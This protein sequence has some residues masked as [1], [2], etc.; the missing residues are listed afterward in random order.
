M[1]KARPEREEDQGN[2]SPVSLH[3]DA[4]AAEP[5][6]AL[7]DEAAPRA[8]AKGKGAAGAIV[9]G[10]VAALFWVGVVGAYLGGYFGWSGLVALE[11]QILA[12]I[13]VAAFLPPI[14]LIATLFALT[15]AQKLAH[16][17]E[18]LALAAERLTR[19][20]DT[21][22]ANA[23][24]VGRVVRRELDAL[25][26]GLDG[27][28]GRLRALET[29]IEQRVAQLED[30]SARAG[31]KAEN[32][33]AKLGAER[34]RIEKM[35]ELLAETLNGAAERASETLAGR[36]AQ[37]TTLIESAGG[38]LQAAGT[39]L[40][41]QA[42][43]FRAAAEKAA[44]APLAAAVELDR[45]A[46]HIAEA[47]GNA[48]TRAE[49]VLA[50]Q[51]RQ[52]VAM[53]ELLGKLREEAE[54]L[55]AAL[56]AQS[57]AI[58]R[59]ADYL[60]SQS[61]HLEAMSEQGLRGLDVAMVGINEKMTQLSEGFT[62][63]AGRLRNNADAAADALS[64]IV[65]SMREAGQSSE[66]LIGESLAKA[67]KNAKDFIGEAMDQCNHLL[68]AASTV[69]EEAEKAR[70]ALARAAADTER[71]IVAL[72]GVA[73]QEAGRI[74]QTLRSETEQMLDISA[75]TLATLHARELSRRP[76]EP[77]EEALPEVSPPKDNL[78]GLARRITGGRRKVEQGKAEQ[79]K[80]EQEPRARI[81]RSS[82][83]YELSAVLAAAGQGEASAP[84]SELRPN[85]AAALSAVQAVLADRAIDLDAL[86]NGTGSEEV[87]GED[88]W[89]RYLGG[90]RGAF[91]HRLAGAIGPEIVDKIAGL[92]RD[93]DRFH[94]AADSYLTEFE[95]LLTRAR[96]SDRD[97]LLM[98]S[99]LTADTGKIYLAI[100]YALGR[101]N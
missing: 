74:R 44:A 53:T 51:E 55:D 99:L 62:D 3:R 70:A 86:M 95:A 46:N 52:R 100:A 58:A 47:A 68:S 63:E 93:D 43:S 42:N 11:P 61:E 49:F 88:V 45:Q 38:E 67:K 20:D 29:A 41:A 19:A 90:E 85:A 25:Q 75:R 50:R 87:G 65:A 66:A 69:A 26:T 32:I 60:A 9:F 8:R 94:Q 80:A 15:R 97:G 6:A 59:A 92:Y 27:A 101:L 98:S 73:A 24:R 54:A 64:R 36:A 83:D 40:D 81:V 7:R 37:L 72:P 1:E 10:A 21:A 12:L 23:Q 77:T 84:S 35:S 89:R 91:A 5:M 39:T 34:E 78:R 48:V 56:E 71:H 82:G 14:L 22:A 57:N 13:A 28:L 79:N 2:P 76:V 33:A 4:K 30:A 18:E 17:A 16:A 96:E 31:V